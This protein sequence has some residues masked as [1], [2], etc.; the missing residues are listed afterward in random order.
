MN[1]VRINLAGTEKWDPEVFQKDG[2]G[3]VLDG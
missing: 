2:K 3:S 1:E